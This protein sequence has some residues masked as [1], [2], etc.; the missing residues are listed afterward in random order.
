MEWGAE[1]IGRKEKDDDTIYVK[2]LLLLTNRTI[3]KAQ[4]N[5]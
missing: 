4:C 2:C 5:D 3:G 1:K